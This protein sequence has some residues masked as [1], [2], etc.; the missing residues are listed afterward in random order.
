M[1][2]FPGHFAE[3]PDSQTRAG[4]GLTVYRLFGKSQF[5]AQLPHF[6]LEQFAQRFEQGKLHHLRQTANVMVRLDHC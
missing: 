4:E 5:K 6:I 3:D 1:E 2:P